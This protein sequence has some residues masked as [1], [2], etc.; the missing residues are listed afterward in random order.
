[1]AKLPLSCIIELILDLIWKNLVTIIL[2][3]L[4][5][6]DLGS[7]YKLFAVLDEIV[8]KFKNVIKIFLIS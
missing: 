8:V 4:D 3:A 5:K 2:D 7:R 1:M 6:Y